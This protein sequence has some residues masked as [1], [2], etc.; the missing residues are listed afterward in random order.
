MIW[1]SR[2]CM[3]TPIFTFVAKPWVSSISSNDRMPWS[4]MPLQRC[5]I[6]IYNKKKDL[7]LCLHT[8]VET[9]AK[10]KKPSGFKYDVLVRWI[11]QYSIKV[12]CLFLTHLVPRG[13][14]QVQLSMF[15]RCSSTLPELF[16]L[17]RARASRADMYRTH[18]KR[19]RE[20]RSG[21]SP[22]ANIKNNSTFQKEEKKCSCWSNEWTP[23]LPSSERKRFSPLW[24]PLLTRR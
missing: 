15:T 2:T 18:T 13:C 19:E 5:K 4:G 17:Q 10:I 14:W 9:S 6:L 23:S 8:L 12:K 20:T 21:N 24:R 16:Q 3:T 1:I 11:E 7:N 22:Q